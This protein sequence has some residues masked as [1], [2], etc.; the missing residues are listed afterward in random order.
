MCKTKELKQSK[1]AWSGLAVTLLSALQLGFSGLDMTQI[2]NMETAIPEL[3]TM[4][5]GIA[6]VIWRNQS[7]YILE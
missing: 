2:Q 7:K 3:I 4:F 1:I 6:I 5:A